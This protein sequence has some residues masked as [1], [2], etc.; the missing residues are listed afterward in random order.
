V[1][2]LPRTAE[3]ARAAALLAADLPLAAME[4]LAACGALA[5]MAEDR[6]GQLWVAVATA[7]GYAALEQPGR[8]IDALSEA[9]AA[10]GTA[11]APPALRLAARATLARLHLEA[12]QP[13]AALSVCAAALAGADGAGPAAGTASRELPDV[14]P[15]ARSVARLWLHRAE[16]EAALGRWEASA[17]AADRAGT[18]MRECRDEAGEAESLYAL[19]RAESALRRPRDAQRHL[20]DALRRDAAAGRSMAEARVHAAMAG[21]AWS[22]GDTA[23]ALEHGSA[24]L[25]LLWSRVGR[26][27]RWDV[28]D[29]CHLFGKILAAAGDRQL[30]I[31][32]LSRAAAYF[33]QAGDHGAA[34]AAS[35]ALDALLREPAEPGSPGQP[36]PD[37]LRQRVRALTMMLG[38]LDDLASTD[39]HLERHASVVTGYA[40]KLGVAMG[41]DSER[42]SALVHACR[43]YHLGRSAAGDGPSHPVLGAEL[44]GAFPLPEETLTA[45]RHHRERWDGEGF[46]SGLAAD[47]IPP[48]ARVLALVDAYVSLALDPAE[49]LPHSGALALVAARSGTAYDPAV[50]R[51]FIHLHEAAQA[52]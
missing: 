37:E 5:R 26:F 42:L 45:V 49:P 30:A 9:E 3:F 33:G 6:A 35:A 41:F 22:G 19:G 52:A 21:L 11:A 8:G 2:V 50:V 12:R 10:T 18:L 40:L 16:A 25:G 13:E 39:P 44:L 38:L 31:Q 7:R 27:D 32:C 28:A 20:G 46:P 34:A 14:P 24:A 15:V 23:A 17:A 1:S 47:E 43:L 4:R 36:I 48:L 29:L 51:A